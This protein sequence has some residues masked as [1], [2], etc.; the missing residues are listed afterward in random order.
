MD[1]KCKVLD[2]VLDNKI[3]AILDNENINITN[4]LVL[5]RKEENIV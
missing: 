4:E 1:I 5:G 2:K 3:K